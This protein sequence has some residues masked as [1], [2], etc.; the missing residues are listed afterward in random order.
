MVVVTLLDEP[1]ERRPIRGLLGAREVDALRATSVMAEMGEAPRSVVVLPFGEGAVRALQAFTDAVGAVGR[2]YEVHQAEALLARLRGR[3]GKLARRAKKGARR[4]VRD[5]RRERL[6][7]SQ[8]SRV[9]RAN[10]S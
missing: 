3:G 4:V 5:D 2:A 7:A 6:V 9:G 10:P 1:R 8:R